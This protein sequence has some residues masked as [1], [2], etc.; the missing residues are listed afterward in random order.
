MH[1]AMSRPI[2]DIFLYSTC[3]AAHVFGFTSGSVSMRYLKIRHDPTT[4]LIKH[5]TMKLFI[6]SCFFSPFSTEINALKLQPG[7]LQEKVF[8]WFSYFRTLVEQNV[9]RMR[10]LF[11][12]KYVPR[13]LIWKKSIKFQFARPDFYVEKHWVKNTVKYYNHLLR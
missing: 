2:S 3:S 12:N 8:W 9:P 11:S 4:K 7:T 10:R 5:R 1:C 6:H 13:E